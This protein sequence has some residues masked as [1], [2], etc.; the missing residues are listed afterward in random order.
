[1]GPALVGRGSARPQM[2]PTMRK[3]WTGTLAKPIRSFGSPPPPSL[4]RGRHSPY[5]ICY[6]NNNRHTKTA[7]TAP[8]KS[9]SSPAKMACRI[10]VIPTELK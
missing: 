3:V 7:A 2:S 5:H 1:M 8:A 9:A 10:R 4:R 6:P